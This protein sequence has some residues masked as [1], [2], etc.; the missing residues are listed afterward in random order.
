MRKFLAFMML[1]IC[2]VSGLT[3]QTTRITI[4]ALAKDAKFIGTGIGGAYIVVKDHYT[5]E[6]LAKGYTSGASGNTD[7]IVKNPRVRHAHLSDEETAKFIAILDI[8][9]PT[10]LDIEAI[11]PIKRKHAAIRSS[12]QIWAIPGKDILGDGIILEIPGFIVDILSPTTHQVIAADSDSLIIRTNLVLMCGCTVQ[13]GGVWDAKNYDV[14]ATIWKE[15]VEIAKVDLIKTAEDNVFE[16]QIPVKEPGNYE[17]A[18]TAFDNK[19]YNTGVD[20]ISF[21]VK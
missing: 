7:V 18:V 15:G 10:L 19:V 20:R 6:V 16:V 2:I 14:V 17:I 8:D 3:A 12:T 21:V 5:Q 13:E 1:S 4:R 9:E 11:A